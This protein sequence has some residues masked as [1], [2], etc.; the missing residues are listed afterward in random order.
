MVMRFWLGNTIIPL[1]NSPLGERGILEYM[2][3]ESTDL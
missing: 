2:K 1:G 3:Q